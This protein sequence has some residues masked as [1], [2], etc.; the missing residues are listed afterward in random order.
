MFKFSPRLTRYIPL[1]RRGFGGQCNVEIWFLGEAGFVG[2][3]KVCR[4]HSAQA[5]QLDVEFQNFS[6]SPKSVVASKCGVHYAFFL[7]GG[8][9]LRASPLSGTCHRLVGD[10]EPYSVSLDSPSVQYAIFS[11]DTRLTPSLVPSQ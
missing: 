11:L 7:R 2:W 10:L 1:V 3:S 8:P 5:L 9:Q 4:G 6:F